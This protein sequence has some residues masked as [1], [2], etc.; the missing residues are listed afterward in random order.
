MHPQ[1]QY[2]HYVCRLI[3]TA[4][5]EHCFFL[6]RARSRAFQ[7]GQRWFGIHDQMPAILD[8][9]LSLCLM[10]SKS[11]L[12]CSTKSCLCQ[13]LSVEQY[14]YGQP[15]YKSPRR[16]GPGKFITPRTAS[17]GIPHR[18]CSR[19]S[20][21]W[22]LDIWWFSCRPWNVTQDKEHLGALNAIDRTTT[23]VEQRR[24]AACHLAF[25]AHGRAGFCQ[26]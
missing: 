8:C 22:R 23:T 4:P 26:F 1:L 16:M 9:A 2:K 7:L 14:R 6:P 17:H 18:G 20:F 13:E 15:P 10:H 19:N 21:H 11:S 5:L 12:A 24:L 25:S 3:C